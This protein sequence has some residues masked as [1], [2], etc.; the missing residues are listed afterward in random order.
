[1]LPPPKN[2]A[3]RI[4]TGTSL[5]FLKERNTSTPCRWKAM[6]IAPDAPIAKQHTIASTLDKP[7]PGL[8]ARTMPTSMPA[9]KSGTPTSVT[10]GPPGT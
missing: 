1:M 7:L 4:P 10:F 8:T 6:I 5:G 2:T 3:K 9:P